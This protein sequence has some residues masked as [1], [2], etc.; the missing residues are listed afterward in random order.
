MT[1]TRRNLI[2]TAMLSLA[3]SQLAIAAEV[4]ASAR[5]RELTA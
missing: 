3:V 5:Y 1:M 4:L 2:Q